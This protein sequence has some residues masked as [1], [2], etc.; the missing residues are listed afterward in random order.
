MVSDYHAALGFG[1]ERVLQQ[2][3][4]RRGGQ[5]GRERAG[6]SAEGGVCRRRRR[7]RRQR[8]RREKA[9]AAQTNPEAHPLKGCVCQLVRGSGCVGVIG[10]S[11]IGSGVPNSSYQLSVGNYK[12]DRP[13]EMDSKRLPEGLAAAAAAAWR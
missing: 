8:M 5:K 7:R 11:D 4:Q 9:R 10:G 12:R 3:R 6:N 13:T 2:Q 1:G